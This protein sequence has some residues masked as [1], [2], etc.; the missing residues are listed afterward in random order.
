MGDM[1]THSLGK[2]G[3][4]KD[5]GIWPRGERL[6]GSFCQALTKLSIEIKT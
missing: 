3:Y 4:L 1:P 2:G 6:N 5:T